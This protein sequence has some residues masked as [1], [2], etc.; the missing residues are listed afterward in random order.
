MLTISIN[1]R[2]FPILFGVPS[3]FLGFSTSAFHPIQDAPP[4]FWRALHIYNQTFANNYY[5]PKFSLGYL[6]CDWIFREPP[7]DLILNIGNFQ[8]KLDEVTPLLTSQFLVKN[9]EKMIICKHSL[10]HNLLHFVIMFWEVHN[11]MQC[12]TINL[13]HNDKP[14]YGVTWA[15]TEVFFV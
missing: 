5:R 2:L 11:T 15:C 1:S 13:Q 7:T 6:A 14:K 8:K 12:C 3:P 9:L 10:K 4:L